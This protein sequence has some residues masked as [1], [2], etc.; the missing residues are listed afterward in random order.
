MSRIEKFHSLKEHAW[1]G[2]HYGKIGTNGRTFSETFIQSNDHLDKRAF[3]QAVNR[4]G[5]DGAQLKNVHVIAEL[6]LACNA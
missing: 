3:E 1:Y 6:L 2:K 5:I 4:I